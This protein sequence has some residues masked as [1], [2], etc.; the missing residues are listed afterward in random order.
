MNDTREKVYYVYGFLRGEYGGDV[1]NGLVILGEGFDADE[2]PRILSVG[3]GI[4][5]IVCPVDDEEFARRYE[6]YERDNLARIASG[7]VKH[8]T[9]LEN[10]LKFGPVMPLRFDEL[11]KPVEALS[12]FLNGRLGPIA[13][14][15]D[16]VENRLEWSVQVYYDGGRCRRMERAIRSG[17][18][19]PDADDAEDAVL[20]AGDDEWAREC[21]EEFFVDLL[22]HARG[23]CELRLLSREESAF[24]SLMI[25]NWAFLTDEAGS[26]AFHRIV[27]MFSARH[28]SSGL[29]FH[30]SGP[31]P[32][33]SFCPALDEVVFDE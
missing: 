19:D 27:K 28:A 10:A 32:P 1:S 9:V 2:F 17:V 24:P 12:D 21:C 6:S 30:L 3:R 29:T 15:F 33:Y 23:S 26:D 25:A 22:R 4:S 31:W 14:F 5:A 16:R 8:Q 13:E 18:S 11:R 7:V 20:R